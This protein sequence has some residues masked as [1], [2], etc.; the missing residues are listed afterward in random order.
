MGAPW[1]ELRVDV[2]RLPAVI[3]LPTPTRTLG[4]TFDLR[5]PGSKSLTNRALLLAALTSGHCTLRGALT[6]AD[7]T[8]VMIDAL[9]TLGAD[10]RVRSPGEITVFGTGGR[11]RAPDGGV[12]L[13]LENAGT[14]VR[15]LAGACVLATG[16]V[17]IDGSARMRERPIADL[18][19]SLSHLGCVVDYLAAPGCPPLR[20]TP[21]ALLPVAPIV[22]MRESASSQFVS[23]LLMAGVYLPGGLTLRSD[24]DVTSASYVRMTLALLTRLGATVQSSDDLR[25][26]RVRGVGADERGL[27]SFDL[28]IEPDASAMTAFWAGAALW[29][30]LTARAQGLSIASLQGDAQLP[31]LLARMGCV[32]DH[33]P[34]DDD[35]SI[36]VTGTGVLRPLLADVSS[37]P[38]SAMAL[39]V[40]AS[41]ASGTSILRGVRT[42]RLKETDR[43]EALRTE[44]AKIGVR[45]ECP[46]REDD[47]AMTISPPDGG[48]DCSPDVSRIEFESHDDHRTA[49][50]LALVALRRPNTFLKNPGCVSKT[51]PAFWSDWAD[52]CGVFDGHPKT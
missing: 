39:A 3:A 18:G 47:E 24:E 37:M 52:F 22:T 19:D 51:Y 16:P 34:G 44:L 14:A 6:D 1:D 40:V 10:I 30:G 42:L 50:A 17:T 31:R 9:R 5:P 41:F 27:A 38:D 15:F 28:S 20:I 25:V 7:D 48:V 49:M 11:L 2:G 46:I 43:V 35:A 33:E 13:H 32:S 36:S 45:V 23:A 29:D 12:T 4:A 26:L 21:P 8:R